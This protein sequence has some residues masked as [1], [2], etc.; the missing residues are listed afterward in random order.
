MTKA[1]LIKERFEWGL[2]IASE[3]Q[4]IIIM[5]QIMVAGRCDVGE[6]VKSFIL[7]HKQREEG[8]SGIGF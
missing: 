8:G 4:S 7:I 5:V 3:A 1:T 6:V 2:L